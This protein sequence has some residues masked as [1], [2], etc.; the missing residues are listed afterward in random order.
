FPALSFPVGRFAV[1]LN[2]S[3]FDWMTVDA[4]RNMKMITAY[5]WDHGTTLTMQEA[6]RM[7]TGIMKGQVE[8][9]YDYSAIQFDTPAYGWSS[10][11]QK[12]GIWLINPSNEYMSGGATKLELIAH[13]DATFTDSLTAPAPAT[14]L[15]VWKGPHYGGTN[16]DAEPGEDWKKTIS[17]FLLYFNTGETPDSA[18]K[19][20]LGRAAKEQY[21]WAYDWA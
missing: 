7:N 12:I 21:L 3:V 9:K 8:H 10:T 19:D 2:D 17:T 20:A 11:K 1:K 18:W 5:D 16:A 15:N 6:R 14:I 4:R 13:R